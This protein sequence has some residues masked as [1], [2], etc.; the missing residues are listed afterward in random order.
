MSKECTVYNPLFFYLILGQA[1]ISNLY[2]AS[3]K[4]LL[5]YFYKSRQGVPGARLLL[6]S[7]MNSKLKACLP[8]AAE[9]QHTAL[10]VIKKIL[11]KDK[12]S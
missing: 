7:R 2:L 11:K 3:F 12:V 1:V 10:R 8:T 4:G 9:K 6:M 5:C